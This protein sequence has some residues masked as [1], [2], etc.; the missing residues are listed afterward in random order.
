MSATLKDIA[1]KAGVSDVTVSNVLRNRGRFGTDTRKRVLRAA[2]ELAYRPHAGA[3]AIRSG[4]FGCVALLL[5]SNR[6]YSS[7]PGP[8]LDALHVALAERNLHLTLAQMPDER[9]TSQGAVPKILRELLSDGLLINYHYRIPRQ[10]IDLIRQYRIPS[11]WMNAKMPADCVYPDDRRAGARA[12]EHLIGLG[13]RRIA[14]VDYSHGRSAMP[15]AHYS[16]AD[17]ADGYRDAMRQAGLA[18]RI[19]RGGGL[20]V[21]YVERQADAA[22]WL[23]GNA[24]PTAVLS[25]GANAIGPI[26][27]AAAKIG[28]DVPRDLSLMTFSDVPG[29]YLG[30]TT[31]TML[32][33]H[34]KLG[35]KA[36]QMLM[37][38]ID[39]PEQRHP[40]RAVA[41]GFEPGTTCARAGV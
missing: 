24:R 1:E 29:H 8:L 32:V 7:L 35:R 15:T 13:H 5:S 34:G 30:G 20:S 4:R 22:A 38:K 33:P 18:P 12:A 25:Y 14:Y 21:P 39:H 9:L 16:A 17:R 11:V 27:L 3:K 37:R 2:E 10:M 28:L 40:P 36:V 19:I 6:A 23:R 41:F 26:A 31:T